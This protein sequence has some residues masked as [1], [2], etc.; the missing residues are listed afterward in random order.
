MKIVKIND[1]EISL[2][3]ENIPYIFSKKFSDV[4]YEWF[5]FDLIKEDVHIICILSYKDSFNIDKSDIYQASIY[6]TI[7]KSDELIA[8]SYSSYLKNSYFLSKLENWL[9]CNDNSLDLWLPDH[10]FKKYINL[11][12]EHKFVSKKSFNISDFNAKGHYWQFINS[13]NDF[14]VRVN[15]FDLDENISLKN[16][17]R[18][19]N[20]FYDYPLKVKLGMKNTCILNLKNAKY[21]L[22]HNFGFSPLYTIKNSWYWWHNNNE[23]I[24]IVNYF[25]PDLNYMYEVVQ[26]NNNIKASVINWDEKNIRAEYKYNIFGV[27]Y[28]KIINF[29]NSLSLIFEKV[30]ESAPFYQRMKESHNSGCTLESLHPAKINTKFNQILLNARKIRVTKEIKSFEEISFYQNISQICK[31]I[32]WNHGKSFYFSSLVLSADQRNSS[33]FIYVLCRLIDDATDEPLENTL[34]ASN[35]SNFSKEILKYLWSE[36]NEIPDEFLKNFIAHISARLYSVINYDAALDFIINAKLLIKDLDLEKKHFLELIRGQKMDENF[37]QPKNFNDLYLYCFRVAGV[38]G[39]MMA[40]I[41]K[42][43][44]NTTAMSAAEKLG[45]A[46]QITNILRDIKEDYENNRIY[47]PQTLFEKYNLNDY[48]T[49]FLC[50]NNFE[51]KEN[52]INELINLAVLLYCESLAGIKYIPSFRA[53]LCVKLMIAVYGSILGRIILDK[54]VVFRKRVVISHFKKLIIFMKILFGFHPLKVANLINEKE[55]L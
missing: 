9:S 4:F 37:I 44:D 12:L 10:S 50:E 17:C 5:Y 35:G 46:L 27:K 13:G 33:Y 3:N 42:T 48:S 36:T 41:F 11:N 55:M 1:C 7:Y 20:I 15:I 16:C 39:L 52:V 26:E 14:N 6:L 31:K 51:N 22:D 38:V 21:Y 34:M 29:S 23:N 8:Y 54:S 25:F 53:R 2:L 18:R 45:C 47:I 30:I 19:A 32:T 43:K 40:K 49:F 24:K 28:P